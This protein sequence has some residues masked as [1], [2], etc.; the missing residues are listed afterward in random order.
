MRSRRQSVEMTKYQDLLVS[1]CWG[2]GMQGI[3]SIHGIHPLDGR[4]RFELMCRSILVLWFVWFFKLHNLSWNFGEY[5]LNRV[6]SAKQ[7]WWADIV[8]YIVKITTSSICFMIYLETLLEKNMCWQVR[9]RK[10]SHIYVYIYIFICVHDTSTTSLGYIPGA[11][12]MKYLSIFERTDVF[13]NIVSFLEAFR[14]I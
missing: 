7:A 13:F 11:P 9:W 3:P 12:C 1:L 2:E 5:W 10:S 8:A 14:I 4:Y 6:Q